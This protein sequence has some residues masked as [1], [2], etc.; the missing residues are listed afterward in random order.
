[1]HKEDQIDVANQGRV[2]KKASLSV[3]MTT[4]SGNVSMLTCQSEVD[5]TDPTETLLKG[6]EGIVGLLH[7]IG[8]ADV[9]ISRVAKTVQQRDSLEESLLAA[10]IE[11]GVNA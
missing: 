10:R 3:S 6:L 2:L 7:S 4:V 11:G 5:G 9:A 1:M 8:M